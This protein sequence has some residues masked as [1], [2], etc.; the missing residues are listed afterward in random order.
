MSLS[1]FSLALIL[2]V[3]ALD[4]ENVRSVWRRR[5]LDVAEV[6]CDDYTLVIPLYGDPRY[7]ADRRLIERHKPNVLVACDVGPSVMQQFANQLEREG[8]RVQRS[9]HAHPTAPMLI[10]S[11]LDEGAIST[12]YT[13]K[14]DADTVVPEGIDRAIE[15]M[16][17]DGADVCSFKC[18]VLDPRSLCEKL[19]AQEY[20]M[21]MLSRHHRPW[22]LSG[23]CYAARTSLFREVLARHT[24]WLFAEDFEFGRIARHLHLRVRHLEFTVYTQVP[25]GWRELW[26]QRSVGWWLGSFQHNWVNLDHNVLLTPVSSFYY[27]GVVGLGFWLRWWPLAHLTDWPYLMLYLGTMFGA[28]TVL[29]FAANWRVRSVWLLLMPYYSFFQSTLMTPIGLVNYARHAVR[30]RSL[31]RYHVGYRREHISA[32]QPERAIGAVT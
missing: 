28:Y 25:S 10:K 14:V 32:R 22:L 29:L 6:G 20:A 8:W 19:Q 18:G 9:I 23:A 4:L 16:R 15:S 12:A 3:V 17:R 31:G 13:L 21:A 11:A 26:R 1:Y 5:V 24:L 2:I 7:F 27:V 30:I